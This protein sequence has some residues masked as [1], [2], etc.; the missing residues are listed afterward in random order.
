MS[1]P[2]MAADNRTYE[3]SAIRQW[4]NRNATSPITGVQL[5]NKQLR[6]N[7]ALRDALAADGYSVENGVLEEE[8]ALSEEEE[9]EDEGIDPE[10][11]E[12]EWID[13]GSSEDLGDDEDEALPHLTEVLCHSDNL[14]KVTMAALIC[15][16]LLAEGRVDSAILHSW[17]PMLVEILHQR[18]VQDSTISAGSELLALLG[19]VH[20]HVPVDAEAVAQSVVGGGR[21]YRTCVIIQSAATFSRTIASSEDK[22]SLSCGVMKAWEGILTFLRSVNPADA[23]VGLGALLPPLVPFL[24]YMACSVLRDFDSFECMGHR[25]LVALMQLAV[26]AHGKIEEEVVQLLV[27]QPQMVARAFGLGV[28]RNRISE[29]QCQ[30]RGLAEELGVVEKLK[31]KSFAWKCACMTL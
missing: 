6:T 14:R 7:W 3:R 16:K 23:E 13:D 19:D 18:L 30:I 1:D 29:A 15:E 20:R 5:C 8:Y 17:L 28:E 25:V 22:H 26:K 2:V 21:F 12:E 9:K 27:Q 10:E 24:A 11:E 4:L 31:A